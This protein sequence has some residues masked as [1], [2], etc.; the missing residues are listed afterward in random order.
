MP[1]EP[2][3]PDTA[4]KYLQE[5]LP[6]QDNS[7]L[8]DLKA[9]IEELLEYR[10]RALTEDELPDD[11]TVVDEGQKGSIVK[12]RVKCGDSS[13]HCMKGGELH[14]PYLYRYF[15]DESGTKTS[16]YVGKPSE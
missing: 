11:A 16:E 7:T 2:K 14:G 5:G 15:R 4:P 6:K 3:P 10:T 12:E 13:C 1:S 8:R 9:Y